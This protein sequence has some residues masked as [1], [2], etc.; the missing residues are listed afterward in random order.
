[1]AIDVMQHTSNTTKQVYETLQAM[2]SWPH[3]LEIARGAEKEYGMSQEEFYRILPEFQRFMA[4][5]KAFPGLGMLSEKV[6]MLWH[7]LILNTARYREFCS[8]YIGRFVD[9]LPCSSYELYGFSQDSQ[10]KEPPA[11]CTDPWPAPPDPSPVPDEM[12]PDMHTVIV[13][14]APRFV[15]LYT[16]IFGC[17]PDP[18]I[19]PR[20]SL[21]D[22]VAL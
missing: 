16:R 6:D 15:H 13:Q 10:C 8:L 14:G 20:T 18:V 12:V 4:L 11:T 1:M 2:Q 5:L 22:A 21:V 17:A 3:W 9:H 19:W 7:S